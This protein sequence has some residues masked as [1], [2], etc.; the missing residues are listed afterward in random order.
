[1]SATPHD[2][3]IALLR[4]S[5]ETLM[6]KIEDLNGHLEHLETRLTKQE[7]WHSKLTGAWIAVSLVAGFLLG[8]GGF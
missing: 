4:Q 2:V 8:H 1:M 7:H 6:E 5:V 3:A